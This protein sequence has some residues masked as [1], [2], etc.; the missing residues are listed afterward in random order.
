[1][2]IT[3]LRYLCKGQRLR[4]VATAAA[5]V[6]LGT[7]MI[8]LLQPGSGRWQPRR[9]SLVRVPVTRHCSVPQ[10]TRADARIRQAKESFLSGWSAG[11]ATSWEAPRV[12]SLDTCSP[13]SCPVQEFRQRTCPTL[14]LGSMAP[15]MTKARLRTSRREAMTRACWF[16]PPRSYRCQRYYVLLLRTGSHLLQL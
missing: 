13:R 8:C 16:S 2:I 15:R 6:G 1:M 4:G 12:A 7:R 14:T 9:F 5:S 11:C 10:T 3:H